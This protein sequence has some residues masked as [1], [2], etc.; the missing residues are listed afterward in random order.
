MYKQL[1]IYLALLLS[2][3]APAQVSWENPILE[4]EEHDGLPDTYYQDFEED[5]FGFIWILTY[6][7]VCRYDGTLLECLDDELLPEQGYSAIEYDAFRKK[8]WIT[9]SGGLYSYD[10]ISQEVHKYEDELGMGAEQILTLKLDRKG[11]VWVGTRTHLALLDIGSDSLVNVQ[12][13]VD[14][15]RFPQIVFNEIH[16]LACDPADD[17]KIWMVT[18]GG[19]IKYQVDRNQ[20]TYAS[21]EIGNSENLIINEI[22]VSEQSRRLYFGVKKQ[23]VRKKSKNYFIYDAQKNKPVRDL[24]FDENWDNRKITSYQDSLILF[25]LSSG[26]VIYNEKQDKVKKKLTSETDGSSLYR[27]DFVDS[28]DHIWSGTSEG[29]KMYKSNSA[30]GRSFYYQSAFPDWYHIVANYMHED[31]VNDKLY[32]PVF[33]G[34]GLY[35]F[36]LN[37]ERWEAYPI[38]SDKKEEILKTDFSAAFSYKDRIRVLGNSGFYDF[39]EKER[40]VVHSELE[41][42]DLRNRSRGIMAS[43]GSYWA[44]TALGVFRIDL[45]KQSFKKYLEQIYFC[46]MLSGEVQ[47]LEDVNKN[48][49]IGGMCGGFNLYDVQKDQFY[50]FDISPWVGEGG[51]TSFSEKDG[52]LWTLCENGM[53]FQVDIAAPEKG[54]T[55]VIDLRKQIAEG[56]IQLLNDSA[57]EGDYYLSGC[58]DRQGN[59]WFFNKKGLYCYRPITQELELF[60]S[61]V[62][63]EVNDPSMNVF[64]ANFLKL[65]S[66]GR[67]VFSTRKGICIFDPGQLTNVKE[68]P[69]PYITSLSVNNKKIESD[70]GSYFKVSYELAANENFIGID[71]SALAFSKPFGIKY[72]YMMEGVDEEWKDPGEKR[73]ITYTK[74]EGGEYKFYLKAADIAGLWSKHAVQIELNIDKYW[75]NT[76]WARGLFLSLLIFAVCYTY[77]NRMSRAVEKEQLKAQYEK[78]LA[79]L[80]MQALTAQMNPHFIFNSLNSIDY[81]IIKNDTRKAS[82]YLNRFSMLMRLI[83][84]NS[85]SNYVSL[86]DDLDAL[87]LYLEIEALR[88]DHKFEYEIQVEDSI[89]QD[90]IKIPPMLIQPYVENSI[91]HGLLHQREDGKIIVKYALDQTNE[92]I[93]CTITDNGIG[94]KKS[95]ELKNGNKDK[96]NRKSFGMNITRDKIEVINYLHDLNADVEIIDLYDPQD[97]SAGTMVELNIPV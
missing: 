34:E 11:R 35:A 14:H 17:E 31:T 28:R 56:Q 87:K 72:N 75:Y 5:E 25:S 44:I 91:W 4:I 84:K 94:R 49:W 65:L 61:D 16:A 18:D 77:F 43:D 47:F 26:V 13:K 59:F 33:G 9:S 48:I 19:V 66:D 36:D 51:I 12:V 52:I 27:V 58:L 93:K 85:R 7:G 46:E 82:Q 2:Y 38:R 90:Y 60:H 79:E 22:Y 92:I 76:T 54:I 50:S 41:F 45:E 15:P 68:A 53:I 10:I 64:T 42:E 23:R 20:F 57:F 95:F 69:F 89:D 63:I 55:T 21:E 8:M 71:F 1:F 86:R 70:S 81:Y 62:G 30:N 78:E 3:A 24:F 80:K 37:E 40:D 96:N 73:F 74:L 39:D 6:K 83:L 97:V 67:M 29:V 88:F 32:L